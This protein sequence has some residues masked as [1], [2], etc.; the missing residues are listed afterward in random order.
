MKII[1][2]REKKLLPNRSLKSKKI[3][4]SDS[5]SCF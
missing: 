3:S 1:F 4:T 2:K 5:S